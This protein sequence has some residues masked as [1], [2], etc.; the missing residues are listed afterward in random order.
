M[1]TNQSS[2]QF[3]SKPFSITSFWVQEGNGPTAKFH[4]YNQEEF[5]KNKTAI[6]GMVRKG[7]LEIRQ[8]NFFGRGPGDE[9]ARFSGI[10]SVELTQEEALRFLKGEVFFDFKSRR[11]IER[12]PS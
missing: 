2:A 5:V 1:K 3:S 10:D 6:E 9:N 4:A 12:K 11:L 7:R 8:S